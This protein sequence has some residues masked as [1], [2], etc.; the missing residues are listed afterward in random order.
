[1]GKLAFMFPGQA[2]QYPGMGKDFAEKF[3]TAAA[4]FAEADRALGGDSLCE[5]CF[6]GS[7]EALKKTVN[8]Q[9][10]ILM[11]SVAAA[12]LLTEKGIQPDYVI[13]HSLGEFS[14]LVV[15]GSLDFTD[16]V[17]LVRRRG[18]YMQEAVPEGQGAMAAIM[19]LSPAQVTEI[20]RKSST[21]DEIAAPANLNSPDQTVIS[22]S[23]AAVKRAVELASQA[24]AK[25]A[26]ILPVSAPFHSEMMRPA[27]VRLEGDLLA[28]NFGPLTIPLVTNVDA[29]IITTG[30]EAR[31]ALIRQVTLPVRWEQSIRA[32]LEEGVTSFVE[33]GPSRVLSGLLRQMD[34]SVHCTNVEDEKSLATTLEKL[35]Q[36]RAEVA[37]P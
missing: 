25:R 37:E 11:V 9:P 32:L 28:T 21:A 27:A 8:T 22:G 15:A 14:A 34:R 31:S 12:R 35:A 6:Q 4:L 29:E 26:V 33:V 23:A 17:R 2:S 5:I 19:G 1:M 7:E 18:Q 36:A 24:G 3:P 10:G 16:A 30:D 13:G 20:C